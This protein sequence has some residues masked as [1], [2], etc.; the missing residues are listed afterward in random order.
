[1]THEP[2]L[3]NR[4][5][6][7]V[8]VRRKQRSTADAW[9]QW[10]RS[11]FV[12]V[13][14]AP[15]TAGGFRITKRVRRTGAH[16]R[17]RPP[18]IDKLGSLV[19]AQYRPFEPTELRGKPHGCVGRTCHRGRPSACVHTPVEPRASN[20][21]QTTQFKSSA[22]SWVRSGERC[23]DYNVAHTGLDRPPSLC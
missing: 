2:T 9:L 1:M 7:V 22:T 15:N 18:R 12:R 21:S 8:R 6:A 13:S 5:F 4:G 19:R 10:L 23:D 11:L 17:E 20:E 14:R 3:R 16:G